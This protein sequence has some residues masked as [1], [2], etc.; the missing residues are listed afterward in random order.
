MHAP[1]TNHRLPAHRS[2]RPSPTAALALCALAVVTLAACGGDDDD[3]VITAS[4]TTT[5]PTTTAAPATIETTAVPPTEAPTTAPGVDAEEIRPFA[6]WP[7]VDGTQRFDDPVDAARSFAVDLVGFSDPVLGEFQQGDATSGE[8]ELRASEGGPLTV[9]L[10][11]QL[12][13]AEGSWWVTAGVHDDIVVDDPRP[14]SAIDDP[15]QVSGQ[16]VAFE[17]TVDVEILA[18]GSTEPRGQG[19][20]TGSGIPPAGPFSGSIEFDSPASGWGAVVFKTHSAEDGNVMAATVVRVG[21]I[22]GD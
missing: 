5:A 8:V 10:V 12:D 1:S 6:L 17:G 19:L 22:G 13:P 20:V 18:D 21:F 4:P 2:R 9:V 16:A 7:D 3:S 14:Q 15:L 11:R